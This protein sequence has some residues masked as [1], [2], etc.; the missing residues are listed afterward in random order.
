MNS[1]LCQILLFLDKTIILHQITDA[2]ILV[3]GYDSNVY[4][5][6]FRKK[7]Q[8]TPGLG[9]DMYTCLSARPWQTSFTSLTSTDKSLICVSQASQNTSTFSLAILL[10]GYMAKVCAAATV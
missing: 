5:E 7:S 1:I 3:A 4:L 10:D 2:I 6:K 8:L 9:K